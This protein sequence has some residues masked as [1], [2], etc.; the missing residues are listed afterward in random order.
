MADMRLREFVEAGKRLAGEDESL[1]RFLE[2][3]LRATDPDDLARQEPSHFLEVLR[4]SHERLIKGGPEETRIFATPPA[5]PGAPLVLD[6]I[7]PDMPFIVDS[8]LAALRAMG[9]AIRLLAHPVVHLGSDGVNDNG[10]AALS[11]LHI[12]SDP[13][14][15]AE[16]LRGEIAL[17]LRD[18]ARAVN[19]WRPMLEAVRGAMGG[20]GGLRA[21]S[22]IILRSWGRA[23]SG[24]TARAWCR[25]PR[26][27]WGFC[28]IRS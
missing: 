25:G 11:V 8:V 14:A 23:S 24:W 26:R 1:A 7:S 2:A 12:H 16:A 5:D 20:L 22:S 4:R 13:V 28:A 9:G 6:V 27:R 3:A 19:D 15:D 21:A 18:V 17:A 10:G